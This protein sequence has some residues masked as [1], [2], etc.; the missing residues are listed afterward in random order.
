MS[1]K[2]SLDEVYKKLN[3][4]RADPLVK[5]LG[6]VADL[7]VIPTG[8]LSLDIAL[9]VGG[10]PIGRIV[11]LYGPESGG[12]STLAL[13]ACVNAQGMGLK[14]LYIDAECA[15]DKVYADKLGVDTDA[16]DIMQPECGEEALEALDCISETGEIGLAVVDSV[17]SLTP[18]SEIEGEIGDASMGV[19][20][21]LMSKALRTLSTKAYSSNTLFLFINQIRMKIGVMFGLSLIHI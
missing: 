14:C 11:E 19:Q 4:G 20:A 10:L 3:K 5:T 12:K 16:L 1:N 17:A 18:R 8:V 2:P 15:L 13:M 21:R 6:E 9:G 7:E